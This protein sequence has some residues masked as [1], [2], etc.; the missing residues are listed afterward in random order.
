LTCARLIRE[1]EKQE[2]VNGHVPIISVSANARSGQI[3]IARS[4]GMDDAISKPFRVADLIPKM[5]G[6]VGNYGS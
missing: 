6:L 1:A 2:R 5:E 4:V 3:E